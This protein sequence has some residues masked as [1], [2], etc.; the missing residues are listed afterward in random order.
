VIPVKEGDGRSEVLITPS[1]ALHSGTYW[2][3]ANLSGPGDNSQT[4]VARS[5]KMPLYA[6]PSVAQDSIRA[7]AEPSVVPVGEVLRFEVAYA[8]M[9][10]REVHIDLFD[11]HTNYLASAFQPVTPGGGVRDMTI[12]FP[13]A[14][15]GEYFITAFMT[16]T[17]KSWRE[18]VAWSAEQKV[19]IVGSDYYEWIQSYWGVVLQNDSILPQDDPDGDGAQNSEEFFTGSN[20]LNPADGVKLKIAR[21]GNSLTVSWPSVAGLTYQLLESPAA[22]ANLWTL[23]GATLIGNGMTL[24]VAIKPGNLSGFYRVQVLP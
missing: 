11:A 16:P 21:P 19:N 23:V 3:E 18:A 12:S 8:A 22:S 4:T 9:T 5:A 15:P 6:A 10:N 2:L 1:S 17:D 13:T 24:Q 20:P 14:L 7:A